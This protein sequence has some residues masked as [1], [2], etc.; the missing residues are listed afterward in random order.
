MSSTFK[1][2]EKANKLCYY[3]LWNLDEEQIGVLGTIPAI[4]LEI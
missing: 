3:E 4:F 2:M 1:Q